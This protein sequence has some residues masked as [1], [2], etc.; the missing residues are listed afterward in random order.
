MTLNFFIY[1]FYKISLIFLLYNST[2]IFL[3]IYVGDTFYFYNLN[4]G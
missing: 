3:F 2:S 4:I 1:V